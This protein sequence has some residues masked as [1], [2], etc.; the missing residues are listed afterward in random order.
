MKKKKKE[1]KER[2]LPVPG[3]RAK[4][5]INALSAKSGLIGFRVKN[6]KVGDVAHERKIR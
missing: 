1:K 3:M 2:C 5:K 4:E 6:L